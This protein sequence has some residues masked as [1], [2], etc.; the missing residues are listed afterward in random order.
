VPVVVVVPQSTSGPAKAA[1]ARE[2]AQVILHGASWSEANALATSLITPDDAFV[3]PFDDPGLWEGH[4]TLIDEVAAAG[5]RPDAVALSVGGGGLMCGVIEGLR[6]HG[7]SDVPIIASETQGA[8]SFAQ[9]LAQGRR[10]E[11]AEITSISPTLGAKQV[12]AQAFDW[13]KTHP[14]QSRVVTDG[15]AA[16]ASLS[17]LDDHRVLTE[18]ACGATLALFYDAPQ[19]LEPFERVLVVVC[20]GVTASREQLE[21]WARL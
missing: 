16:R 11:L 17:F 15:A 21:T 18:P 1:L 12:A 13:T 9:S 8:D 6:R 20:G 10:V 14:I 5:L 2:G 3:H 7:W 19:T 4:A